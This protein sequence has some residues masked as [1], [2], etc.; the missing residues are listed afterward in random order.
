MRILLFVLTLALIAMTAPAQVYKWTDSS[1][2]T[3][4]GDRPPDDAKKQELA[5]ATRKRDVYLSRDSGTTWQ[6]I[7]REGEASEAVSRQSPSAPRKSA[8]Q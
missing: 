4:Y 1:G 6:K 7:A 5:I 2:K 8:L 3:H